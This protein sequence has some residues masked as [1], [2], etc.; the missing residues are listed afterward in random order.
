MIENCSFCW[1][2]GVWIVYSEN[3]IDLSEYSPHVCV[4]MC[5][6]LVFVLPLTQ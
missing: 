1:V 4:Y 5:E 2:C 3:N 6:Y